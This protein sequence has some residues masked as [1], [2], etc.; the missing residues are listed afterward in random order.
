V[1]KGQK[2]AAQALGFRPAQQLRLVVLPQA[3][4]IAVPP[5][6]NQYLNLWKNTSLAFIIGFPEVINIS[7]TIVNQSGHELENF[8]L[9]VLIYLVVSLFLSAVMNVF[10]RLVALRGGG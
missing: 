8:T 7:T 10:N 9:V 5:V 2:E 1:S 4:R 3:M 6:T